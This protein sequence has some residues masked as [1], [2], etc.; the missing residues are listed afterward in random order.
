ETG[1]SRSSQKTLMRSTRSLCAS[2]LKT[3]T[4]SGW[5]PGWAR[6]LESSTGGLQV[7]PKRCM[8]LYG[9]VV[10]IDR[11]SSVLQPAIAATFGILARTAG[12]SM[13]TLG[14]AV[15]ASQRFGGGPRR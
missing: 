8:A 15:I 2:W 9:A 13:R 10:S 12:G 6:L 5:I 4:G 1:Q 7:E 11:W 3:E 14:N